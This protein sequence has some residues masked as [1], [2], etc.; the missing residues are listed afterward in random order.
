MPLPTV[1]DLNRLKR[2]A[3][4]LLRGLELDLRQALIAE[5]DPSGVV[6]SWKGKFDTFSRRC[7]TLAKT[8]DLPNSAVTFVK[9]VQK[10]TAQRQ[11]DMVDRAQ[12]AN[13]GRAGVNGKYVQA[14]DNAVSSALA[15]APG[16][17]M[18][19]ARDQLG[20]AIKQLVDAALPS[21]MVRGDQAGQF[22]QAKQQITSSLTT[23]I[24]QQ[25]PVEDA[26]YVAQSTLLDVSGYLQRQL[27][28]H[29]Q[30]KDLKQWTQSQGTLDSTTSQQV[31]KQ[32]GALG[33]AW[34]D[35]AKQGE[36]AVKRS[37]TVKPEIRL[38][39][40]L[41]LNPSMRFLKD[42]NLRAG[43]TIES[44][45]IKIQLQGHV[46]ITEPLDNNRQVQGGQQLSIQR[47]PWSLNQGLDLSPTNRDVNVGLGYTQGNTTLGAQWDDKNGQQSVKATITIRF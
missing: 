37:V 43:I 41:V 24:Q 25:D 44:S 35:G 5:K 14:Y 9:S 26:F 40:S 6:Q 34:N 47:G 16:Q 36:Q 3:E 11:Q 39:P 7:D 27:T 38:D 29:N 13:D 21:A 22:Q 23:W 33:K 20:R 15:Q 30:I 19:A 8:P 45:Q 4:Q 31:D 10:E 2:D 18:S 32:A 17:A 28:I 46:T 42:V 1:D 12:R